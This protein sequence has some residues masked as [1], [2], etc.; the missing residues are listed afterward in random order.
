M[1]ACPLWKGNTINTSK[2]ELSFSNHQFAGIM[3]FFSGRVILRSKLYVW[4]RVFLIYAVRVSTFTSQGWCWIALRHKELGRVHGT[5]SVTSNKAS[6]K[7][8]SLLRPGNFLGGGGV[9]PFNFHDWML[10][11]IVGGKI[12]CKEILSIWRFWRLPC[13]KKVCVLF[14]QLCNFH[15]FWDALWVLWKVICL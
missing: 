2:K 5:P 11:E 4:I 15:P 14:F 10:W 9:G 6:W 3:F 1:D 12:F 7:G 13:N 8:Q